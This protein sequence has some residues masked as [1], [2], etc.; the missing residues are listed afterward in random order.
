[1]KI[2]TQ[3]EHTTIFSWLLIYKKKVSYAKGRRGKKFMD[4]NYQKRNSEG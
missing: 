2:I 4:V 3:R 1:M